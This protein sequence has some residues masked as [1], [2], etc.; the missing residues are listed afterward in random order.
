MLSVFVR[1]HRGTQGWLCEPRLPAFDYFLLFLNEDAS[2]LPSCSSLWRWAGTMRP[3]AARPRPA[4]PT[5]RRAAR[6]ASGPS[7]RHFPPG[8]HSSAPPVGGAPTRRLPLLLADPS[9]APPPPPPSIW[10]ILRPAPIGRR[11]GASPCDRPG[12][13]AGAGLGG[14]GRGLARRVPRGGRGG[15]S[16]AGAAAVAGGGWRRRWARRGASPSCSCWG[17]PAPPPRWPATSRWVRGAAG[18]RG[19]TGWGGGAPGVRGQR[20]AGAIFGLTGRAGGA[21]APAAR[22]NAASRVEVV[23]GGKLLWELKLNIIYLH[24]AGGGEESRPFPKTWGLR[25]V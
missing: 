8:P 13:A 1:G 21:P 24:A 23:R 18:S 11:F 12:G 10:P 19:G 16:S 6:A 15:R 25:S 7:G 14:K 20:A 5:G 2:P 22:I 4:G 3:E 17:S 9:A